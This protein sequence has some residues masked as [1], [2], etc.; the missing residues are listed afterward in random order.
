MQI[1]IGR[2]RSLI[3]EE[4]SSS[5]EDDFG[6]VAW[7]EER[8]DVPDPREPNGK[9]ERA[10]LSTLEAFFNHNFKNWGT[11]LEDMREILKSGKWSDVIHEP[12]VE[13][14]YRGLYVDEEHVSFLDPRIG[15]ADFGKVIGKFDLTK[16]SAP[17]SWSISREVAE[18]FAQGEEPMSWSG[19]PKDHAVILTARV[20]DN[21]GILLT[22]PGGLYKIP[23]FTVHDDEEEVIA[24][25]VMTA[26]EVEWKY[27]DRAPHDYV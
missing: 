12:D 21:P 4:L 22:C 25:D 20:S 26:C 5:L 11:R 17:T 8:N 24:L 6:K 19:Q 27:V 10:M 9:Q 3:K 15:K 13:Y 7:A 2:V 23:E 18:K 16:F 14:V 1:T